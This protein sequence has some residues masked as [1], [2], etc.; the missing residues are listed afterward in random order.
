[1]KKILIFLLLGINAFSAT[2]NFKQ[3]LENN[4]NIKKI[5]FENLIN[6]VGN[7][8]EYYLKN[9]KFIYIVTQNSN[10]EKDFFKIKKEKY[11][12]D[13]NENLIKYEVSE[14]KLFDNDKISDEL[15]KKANN[16]KKNINIKD[17]NTNPKKESPNITANIDKI[18]ERFNQEMDKINIEL[19]KQIDN[20]QKEMDNFFKNF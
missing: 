10:K 3:N 7:S 8:E 17:R 1:M 13:D 18:E 14:E 9:D 19:N 12:F 2:D 11:Y 16:L 5:A 20:V 6:N 4:K 15:K